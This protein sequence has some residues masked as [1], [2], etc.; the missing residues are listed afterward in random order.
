VPTRVQSVRTGDDCDQ[1]YRTGQRS[2]TFNTPGAKHPDQRHPY[3][4]TTVVVQPDDLGAWIG[5]AG[6]AVGVVLAAGIDWWRS[7]RTGRKELRQRLMQAGSDLAAAATAYQRTTRAAGTAMNEPAWH[8][9]IQT[10]LDAMRI[11]SLTINLAGDISIHHASL[12]IVKAASAP[13]EQD[14]VSPGGAAAF[15]QQTYRQLSD[16][17]DVLNAYWEAVRK[18]KL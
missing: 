4:M 9:L 3:P 6:V 18:A 8:E 17:D 5:V 1:W 14:D 12:Q 16:Q 7:R 11:A 10:R 13:P 2:A 15:L